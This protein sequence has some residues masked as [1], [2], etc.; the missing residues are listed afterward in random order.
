MGLGTAGTIKYHAKEFGIVLTVAYIKAENEYASQ[1]M[2][3]EYRLSTR[4]DIPSPTLQH[5]SEQPILKSEI[6]CA[7]KYRPRIKE[8]SYEIIAGTE[9]NTAEEYNEEIFGYRPIFDWARTNTDVIYGLLRKEEVEVK[10]DDDTYEQM[11]IYN[12]Y[13]WT[14]ALWYSTEKGKRPAL[15]SDFLIAKTDWRNYAQQPDETLI[16]A[17]WRTAAEFIVSIKIKEVWNRPISRLGI[18]ATLI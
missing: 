16:G 13:N 17:S 5:L 6:V 3:A 9:D 4:F 10:Q 11:D 8:D 15:N 14:Q 2:P 7:S 1:G 12:F 18:P